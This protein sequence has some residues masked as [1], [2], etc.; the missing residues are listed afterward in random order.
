VTEALRGRVEEACLNGWPALREVVLDG[1]LLRFSGGHTRR[2]NSVNPLGAGTRPLEKVAL[3]EALYARAGLPTIFRIP[4]F[5]EAGLSAVLDARGYAPVEDETRVVYRDL[6]RDL[7]RDG[8]AELV[9]SAPSAEWLAAHA[10]CNGS[11]AAAQQGQRDILN[12]LAIPAVFAGVR[13]AGGSLAALAFGA[14]HDRI[15]CVNLVVTD[16]ALRRRGLARRAVAA[17]LFWA[18]ERTAAEGACLPVA[19]A[20]APA[21]ALYERLGFTTELYRYHYRRRESASPPSHLSNDTGSA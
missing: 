18:R 5:A 11:G 1:W 3:A 14:V 10:R 16:P 20:N 17:V 15:L 13:G 9:E 8:G 6:A 7:P 2:A 4:S 21:V 12:A 19:A